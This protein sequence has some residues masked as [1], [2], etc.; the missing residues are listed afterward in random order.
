[1]AS[2]SDAFDRKVTRAIPV[3]ESGLFTLKLNKPVA[4]CKDL[5]RQLTKALESET[6]TSHYGTDF[7]LSFSPRPDWQRLLN[8]DRWPELNRQIRQDPDD[9]D[10]ARSI[11]IAAG[12]ILAL[13]VRP[14]APSDLNG[15]LIETL[16]KAADQCSGKNAGV[17]W[18]H[19]A[20]FPEE[21]IGQLFEFSLNGKG[22][23]LN[24]TVA[25]V[26]H[27]SMSSTDRSHI[28][29]VR[30]SGDR[31]DLVHHPVFASNLVLGRAVS[32]GGACYDVPNPLG[33][34]L[35][36]IDV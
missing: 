27:P 18:L 3:A 22:A 32:W 35:T 7:T 8:S 4:S 2:I 11:V 26:L 5:P 28:Q 12:I 24:V 33:R 13:D 34:F 9:G 36:M 6:P 23:G 17:I 20:G 21:E 1:V 10:Y 31:R 29:R 16:K 30:F 14:H 15:C 25:E 19:F